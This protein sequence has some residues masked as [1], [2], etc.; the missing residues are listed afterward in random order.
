[1]AIKK[2]ILEIVFE[3]DGEECLELREYIDNVD[4]VLEAEGNRFV[5]DEEYGKLLDSSIMGLS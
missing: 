4:S 2:Y 5:L 1:M 3:E